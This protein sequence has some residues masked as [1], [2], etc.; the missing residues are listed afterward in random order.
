MIDVN[1][2]IKDVKDGL[3]QRLTPGAPQ[4]SHLP[5]AVPF[6]LFPSGIAKL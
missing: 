2:V 1:K 5:S 6:I 4:I 3:Q